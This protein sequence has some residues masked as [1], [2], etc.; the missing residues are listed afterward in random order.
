MFTIEEIGNLL[1]GS[2]SDY[3][4]TESEMF[5]IVS[6]IATKQITDLLGVVTPGATL[7]LVF[8]NIV[9]Y[10]AM[11]KLNLSE[12]EISEIK[13]NYDGACKTLIKIQYKDTQFSKVIL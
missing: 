5:D 10:L 4:S 3:L 1:S 7:K 8:A 12:T 6:E 9:S 2:V 11:P 13:N